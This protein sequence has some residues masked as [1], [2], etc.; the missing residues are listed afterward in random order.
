MPRRR[1]S[2]AWIRDLYQRDLGSASE[3]DRQA[4]AALHDARAKQAF[5]SAPVRDVVKFI[6]KPLGQYSP[7][8][9]APAFPAIS[10]RPNNSRDAPAEFKPSGASSF[11][12]PLQN[13]DYGVVF[14]MA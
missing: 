12:R 6:L 4:A 2:N 7:L 8:A 9:G 10:S 5:P 3:G 11:Y 13:D 1:R 14:F